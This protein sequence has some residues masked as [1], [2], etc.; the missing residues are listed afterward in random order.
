MALGETQQLRM[1]ERL[2]R[3]GGQPVTLDELRAGGIDFPA[4]VLSELEINGYVI[5]RFH[6]HGRLIGVRLLETDAR[7]APASRWR[8]RWRRPSR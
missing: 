3:A 4:V 8:Q 5:E 6:K 7:D 1:L 2:R